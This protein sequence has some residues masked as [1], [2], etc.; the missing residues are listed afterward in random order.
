[1]CVH[2][3]WYFSVVILS[4]IVRSLCIGSVLYKKFLLSSFVQF[5]TICHPVYLFLKWS[6]VGDN[7]L[8]ILNKRIPISNTSWQI[9]GHLVH[10]V[11]MNF[12]SSPIY[13]AESGLR[14][15]RLG[16]NW[17]MTS[18]VRARPELKT[19]PLAQMSTYIQ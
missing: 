4:F 7:F 3:M 11:E 14:L 16:P 5:K 18:P 10:Y 12:Y 1:M 13:R 9:L 17:A 2:M 15:F 8:G 19:Y 6:F